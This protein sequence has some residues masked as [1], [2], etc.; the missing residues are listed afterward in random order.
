MPQLARPCAWYRHDGGSALPLDRTAAA[1]STKMR[2]VH[3]RLPLVTL[4]TVAAWT[5]GGLVVDQQ[6]GN[7]RSTPA[8]GLHRGRTCNAPGAPPAP[9]THPDA[10]GRRRRDDRRGHRLARLGALRVSPGQPARIRPARTRPRLPRR[11]LARH[12][13]RA[14]DGRAPSRRGHRGSGLGNRGCDRAAGER[15]LGDDRVRVPARR[16]RVDAEAGVRRRIHGRRGARALRHSGGD[17]D[18]GARRPGPPPVTGEPAER[19]GERIRRLRR[20][21]ADAWWPGSVRFS[22]GEGRGP[23]PRRPCPRG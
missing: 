13:A 7:A 12:A 19:R 10:R 11:P 8:R 6:V 1:R 23:P 18:L 15:R 4:V 14:A 22:R 5:L 20:R 17:M 16:A 2:T 9:G 21:R 3:R